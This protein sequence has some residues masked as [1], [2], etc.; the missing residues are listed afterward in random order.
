M[1]KYIERAVRMYIMDSVGDVFKRTTRT[2]FFERMVDVDADKSSLSVLYVL[3]L[4]DRDGAVVWKKEHDDYFDLLK[5][6]Y[7][8]QLSILMSAETE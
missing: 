1:T 8:A 3:A 6:E 5:P 4:K 2:L 7:M